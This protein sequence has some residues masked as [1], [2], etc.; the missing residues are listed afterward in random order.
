MV[1]TGLDVSNLYHNFS[2]T[3][4]YG[5]SYIL[6]LLEMTHTNKLL[7]IYSHKNTENYLLKHQNFLDM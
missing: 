4:N 2:L 5:T 6:L 1:L 3:R 7:V